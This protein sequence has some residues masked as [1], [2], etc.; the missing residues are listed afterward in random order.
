[1]ATDRLR[2][3]PFYCEENVWW[4]CGEPDLGSRR[5]SAVFLTAP[6]GCCPMLNQRAAPPGRWIAW[7]Y[8]AVLV[9]G[10]GRVWDL[11]SSLPL[12][13]PGRGWLEESFAPASRLPPAYRPRFRVVPCGQFRADFASDRSHMRDPRGGW[14]RPPPPWPPIGRGNRLPEYLDP[15]GPTPGRLMSLTEFRDWIDAR[16]REARRSPAPSTGIPG[17]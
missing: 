11:D 15:H 14:L 13:S 12:P 9:D 8:H 5:A 3:Q 2:Y 7:D 4:L 6:A 16:T 17:S 1:V 10:R